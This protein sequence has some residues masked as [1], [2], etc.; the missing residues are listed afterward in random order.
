MFNKKET[1]TQEIKLSLMEKTHSSKDVLVIDKQM[2][3]GVLKKVQ[4]KAD[5]RALHYI[6]DDS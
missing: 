4:S 2:N 5:V 3:G 6:E 1:G